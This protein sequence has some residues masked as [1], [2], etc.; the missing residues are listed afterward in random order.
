[1]NITLE[2][3]HQ[4][5]RTK[6]FSPTYLIY[7]DEELIVEECVEDILRNALD[8]SEKSFNCD[9][10][11]AQDTTADDVVAV[12]NSFPMMS[13]R[14]VVIIKD[15]E[16]L[17]GKEP[18][19]GQEP[20][21]VPFIRYIKNPAHHTVLVLA[22]ENP[23]MRKSPY[24]QIAKH[25]DVLLIKKFY[26]RETAKWIEERVKQKGKTISHDGT[27]VLLENVGMAL[28]TLDNEIEKLCIYLGERNTIN[29]ADA[30]H[31]VGVSNESTVFDL[32]KAVGGK[33]LGDALHIMQRLLAEETPQAALG[34]L[35][36]FFTRVHKILISAGAT[37][38]I[39][40]NEIAAAIGANPRNFSLID[41][42]IRYSR[43][44]TVQQIDAAFSALLRAD[45]A[46]KTTQTDHSVV[47]AEL[48]IQLLK[49]NSSNGSI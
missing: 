49:S 18:R 1:M 27:A 22:A 39:N 23:D 4:S 12:A 24:A 26:E 25:A 44:Y 31:I 14:R 48:L 32:E 38:N 36:R 43:G 9:I 35:A 40:K 6:H 28:R 13:D 41:N 17:Q 7:G 37:G 46:I 5:V 42:Y 15:F 20:D 34:G 3:F 45:T 33:K 29:E 21:D 2:Q 47:M 11:H 10:L 19:K 30:R 16:K 8:E